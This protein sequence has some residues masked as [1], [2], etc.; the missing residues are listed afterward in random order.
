MV[1]LDD[2]KKQVNNTTKEIEETLQNNNDREL[3]KIADISNLAVDLQDRSNRT[4]LSPEEIE[5]YE[6]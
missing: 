1:A 2:F 4:D 5:T 3:V 6:N